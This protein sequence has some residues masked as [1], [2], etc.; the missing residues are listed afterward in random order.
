MYIRTFS[1][2]RFLTSFRR[3]ICTTNDGAIPSLLKSIP[4]IKKIL[5]DDPIS[6]PRSSEKHQQNGTLER[7]KPSLVDGCTLMKHF[8]SAS[9]IQIVPKVNRSQESTI[10]GLFNRSQIVQDWSIFEFDQIPG[11]GEENESNF[12]DSNNLPEVILLGRCNVGKSSL[13]NALLTNV[14]ERV[15]TYAK[16]KQRAGYTLCL[17]FY[18]IGG[19]FRLVDSPGYGNRGKQ[20]QGMLVTDY[21]EKRRVLRNC[22]LLL[23]SKVGLNQYDEM[24]VQHLVQS[25]TSFDVVFNKID[26]IPNDSRIGHLERLIGNSIL[27]D[28]KIQ[29]RYYFVNSVETSKG[30]KYRSGINELR[31]SMLQSCGLNV[32]TLAPKKLQRDSDRLRQKRKLK[33]VK[34]IVNTKKLQRDS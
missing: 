22:Y 32:R 15:K 13:I 5:S 31:L 6:L 7:R 2:R 20:W 19:L 18:N 17:N 34:M 10:N 14:K 9:V 3:L 11:E 27:A 25:G 16:V 33:N 28:L 26:K 12:V 24:I 23:D 8:Q 21:L 4:N 29:P 1:A 30:I